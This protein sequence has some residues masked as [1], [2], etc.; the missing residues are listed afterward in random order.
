VTDPTDAPGDTSITGNLPAVIADMAIGGQ[1]GAPLKILSGGTVLD[2]IPVR[3]ATASPTGLIQTFAGK[4]RV[5]LMSFNYTG[6]ASECAANSTVPCPN[7]CSTNAAQTCSSYLDCCQNS[8]ECS[9]SATTANGTNADGAKVLYLAGSG[10]CSHDSSVTCTTNDNCTPLNA[11]S[12]CVSDGSGSHSSGLVYQIDSL[13]AASWTPFSEAFY[14]AIGYFAYT[15]PTV[16]RTA[17]RINDGTNAGQPVDFPANMNPSQYACQQNNILLISDGVS[18]ADQRSEL[19]NLYKTGAALSGG[20]CA[21]YKG[22][23]N[24]PILSWLAHNKN[25]STFSTSSAA[26]S[27]DAAKMREKITTYVVLNGQDDGV[28][29]ECNSV[30]MMSNTASKGG[31]NF[32]QANNPQE[33]EDGLRRAFEEISAQAASGTAASILSNSEGSGANILQAVFYPKKV[34]DNATEANWVG[35]MQNLWYFVDPYINNSTIREDTDVDFKLN[36]KN[37]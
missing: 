8:N 16:S 15:A 21:A 31:G 25:I 11:T 14:N 32:Y 26:S 37:G 29:G 36:L 7:V 34:F 9:C 23:S 35:E 20:V 3:L 2:A 13:K 10:T 28:S 4:M 30:T 24:L 19:A 33:L 12:T 1:L 17:I 6:S 5:G 27:T 22:S 18:T